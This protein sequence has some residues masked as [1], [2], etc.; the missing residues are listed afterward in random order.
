VANHHVSEFMPV[1]QMQQ[2]HRIRSARNAREVAPPLRRVTEP[3][4]VRQ[5]HAKAMPAR[6]RRRNPKLTRLALDL[7]IGNSRLPV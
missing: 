6:A 4:D 7:G 3:G 5:W 2:R 1:Q